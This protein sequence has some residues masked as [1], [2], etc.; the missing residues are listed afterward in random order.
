[1]LQE[2]GTCARIKHYSRFALERLTRYHFLMSCRT[3]ATAMHAKIRYRIHR[4]L[5]ASTTERGGGGR[6]REGGRGEEERGRGRERGRRREG[7]EREGGKRKEPQRETYTN[8][9]TRKETA[10]QTET[11]SER[12]GER[13]RECESGRRN[14]IFIGLM[15]PQSHGPL[16]VCLYEETL[17]YLRRWKYECPTRNGCM[18]GL[19]RCACFRRSKRWCS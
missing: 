5:C 14:W 7:R 11:K 2:G 12:E 16:P 9:G 1:M 19:L 8:R 10:K 15:V 18:D 6:K 13:K 3:M 4:V 17:G